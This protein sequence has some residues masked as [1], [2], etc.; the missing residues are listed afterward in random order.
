MST[1]S[2]LQIFS[3]SSNPELA[4]K[5]C[6]Y[7]DIPLGAAH[8]G[9]FADGETRIE[10]KSNVRG[11]DVFIVQSTCHPANHH[12]ME[13]LIMVDACR[14]ASANRIT[15][16]LPYFGYAR[17]ERKSAPRTP[18]SAKLVADLMDNGG[19]RSHSCV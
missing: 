8:I 17:Q 16:V 1:E 19:N 3:G 12:I 9:A 13:V 15:L 10:I 2:E 4:K 18:I 6:D 11:N 7:L 14:R 5:I